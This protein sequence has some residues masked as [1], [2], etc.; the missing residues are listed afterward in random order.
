MTVVNF[1][2]K[3]REKEWKYEKSILRELSIKQLRISV[4]TA[5]R[6]RGP[7]YIIKQLREL[8]ESTLDCAVEAY[9]LGANYSSNYIYD[10]S[11]DKT[12]MRCKTEMNQ[13]NH[14]LKQY[15]EYYFEKYELPMVHDIVHQCEELVWHWWKEGYKTGVKRKKLRL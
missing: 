14:I 2:Q 6:L 7:I 8:E 5:F 13:I 4:K 9:L 1:V 12:L 15:I 3:K 10:F 11:M